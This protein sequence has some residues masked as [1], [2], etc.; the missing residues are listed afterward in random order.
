MLLRPIFYCKFL[1]TVISLQR[2]ARL[3]SLLLMLKRETLRKYE[4]C[5][6]DANDDSITKGITK[7]QRDY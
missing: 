1:V 5:V 4:R 2:P 7:I 6:R 3:E